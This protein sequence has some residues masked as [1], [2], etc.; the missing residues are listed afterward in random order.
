MTVHPIHNNLLL[1]ETL[2]KKES[3]FTFTTTISGG[4]S[5]GNYRTFN[6]GLFSGDDES[7]VLENRTRLTNE[8]GTSEIYFPYQTHKD[9]IAII[10]SDF[11]SLPDTEKEKRL[12]GID[13]VITNQKHIC[14]GIGTADCVPILM[15]DRSQ[16]ILA[17]VHAGWRGT[18]ERLPEKVVS[19]LISTYGSRSKDLLVAIGPSISQE[20]FDVGDE[21]IIAFRDAKYDIEQITKKNSITDKYHINLWLSNQLALIDVGIPNENIELSGLCTYANP[22]MFFSARRQTVFS[23]RM[24]TGGILY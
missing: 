9:N 5:K 12:Y 4:V 23:G 7:N 16:H 11:L 20:Y 17:A 14:I 8:I 3:L 6:L 24:I 2:N 19:L 13:A 10:D 15:Y 21:M 18:I 22:E 1:F